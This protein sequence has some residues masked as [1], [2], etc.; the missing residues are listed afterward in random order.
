[1][2]WRPIPFP[3]ERRLETEAYAKRHYRLDTWR[4]RNPRVIV[5]HYTAS[6]TF[7][8]A[9]STF[10]SDVPDGELHELPGICSHFVIDKDGTIY[11]LVAL[12]VMCRHTVGLNWTAIGIEHVGTSDREILR[13]PRQMRA[14]LV[15]SLWLMH[16][17]RINLGDVIGHN[18]SLTSRFH[19]ELYPS[20]RCQTHADWPRVDMDRYRARLAALTRRAG[21]PLGPR[22]RRVDPHC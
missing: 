12:S 5:E 15:L 22:V 11:Q 8:S 9:F 7:S 18:E 17:F 1:M 16:R 3:V 4:L 20:W 21:V 19:R 10:A 2:T 6:E 13:N 14:S